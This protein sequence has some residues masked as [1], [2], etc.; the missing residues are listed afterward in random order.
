MVV[1]LFFCCELLLLFICE[2]TTLL[3][4][5]LVFTFLQGSSIL[6]LFQRMSDQQ[7]LSFAKLLELP[8]NLAWAEY[9]EWY[10]GPHQASHIVSKT[11]LS[12]VWLLPLPELGDKVRSLYYS[13]HYTD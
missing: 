6:I 13:N 2:H 12:R 8:R 5:D 7:P 10:L 4:V 9:G 1:K 3:A 11:E